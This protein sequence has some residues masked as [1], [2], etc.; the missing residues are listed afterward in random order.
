[1]MQ[2]LSR[3]GVLAAAYF[4]VAA[5]LTAQQKPVATVALPKSDVAVLFNLEHTQIAQTGTPGFWLK[6]A[7]IDGSYRF[8]NGLGIAANLTG[9]HASNIA[10]NVSLGKLAYM[11]GP[12]YTVD[13]SRYT[14]G[15]ARQHA[16]LFGEAL[17][18]G[19]HAFDSTF[20]GAAGVQPTANAFSMQLGGGIDLAIHQR[21][22]L[23]LLEADYIHTTLPNNAGNAQNDFRLGFGLSYRR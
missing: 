12:R 20:P 1:M 11:F 4:A 23:R 10:A 5:S 13:A 14:G 22:G 8:Y 19:V 9:E 17:F 16:S 3:T 21:F 2:K 6:G 15:R 18:G 7:S